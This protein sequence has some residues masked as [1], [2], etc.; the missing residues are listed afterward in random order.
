MLLYFLS[1]SSL[2]TLSSFFFVDLRFFCLFFLN[3]LSLFLCSFL[4]GTSLPRLSFVFFSLVHMFSFLLSSSPILK[5]ILCYSYLPSSSLILIYL[6]ILATLFFFS[7]PPSH[8]LPFLPP[9]SPFFLTSSCYSFLCF[10]SP[11]SLASPL[12]SSFLILFLSF[13]S[14]IP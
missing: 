12:L 9:V 3:F 14:S 13:L 6:F 5:K 4:L 8:L 7:L 1:L 10:F 11:F 2:T